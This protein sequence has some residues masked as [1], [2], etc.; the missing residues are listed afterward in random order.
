MTKR[1]QHLLPRSIHLKILGPISF[2][3]RHRPTDLSECGLRVVP[4]IN[5]QAIGLQVSQ[6]TLSIRFKPN[7]RR[8]KDI[9]D[10]SYEQ[11]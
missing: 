2:C 5:R 1:K 8:Y 11:E 4:P 9:A 10:T 7:L 6:A 3:D